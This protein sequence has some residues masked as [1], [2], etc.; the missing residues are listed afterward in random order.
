M[1][2]CLVCGSRK[3]SECSAVWLAHLLWEQR[4]VSSNPTIPTNMQRW[5]SGPMHGIA[6]PKSR[7]FESSPLLQIQE[8]DAVALVPRLALKT[9]FSQNGMGFDS[10][11]FRQT[12][13][14][15]SVGRVPRLHRGCRRF[16]PVRMYQL[17][18]FS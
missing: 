7:W 1:A 9:R 3:N 8:D 16:E 15:N 6:N 5:Q 14:L 2:H 10:S 17:C 18:L 4:V 11:V 12:C 13:I